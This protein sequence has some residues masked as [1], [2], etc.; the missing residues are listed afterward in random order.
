MPGSGKTVL[1]R[2]LES[3][4]HSVINEAATDVI[5]LE[6]ANGHSSPWTSSDFI[7]K[8]VQLQIERR[9]YVGDASSTYQF[10]D[11]SPL[12]TLALALYLDHLP[13]QILLDEIALIKREQVYQKKI[14]FI[15]NLGYCQPTAARTI[16]FEEA[17]RFEKIHEAVYQTHH[18]ELFKI[19]PRPVTERVHMILSDLGHSA[20]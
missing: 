15:E 1:I 19:P 13:P 12:C 11:R 17:V 9:K 10:F 3:I 6:Q 8:I 4:G 14:F 20:F 5:S 16:S 2:H 7:E 18:F